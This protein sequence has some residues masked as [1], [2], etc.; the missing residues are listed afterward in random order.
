MDS[1]DRESR[2]IR[3]SAIGIVTNISLVAVK[4][5]I[6]V[7][8]NSIA[9]MMDAVNNLSD[10]L[11][12]VVT[13]IGTKL[14]MRTPDKKHPFGYGR[15][16]YMTALIVAVIV[17]YAGMTALIESAEHILEPAET[18]YTTISLV[19]IAIAV[20]VKVILGRY[21]MSVGKATDSG[22][23]TASGA[24]ALFDAVLSTSVLASALILVTTGIS[25]EAYVGVLIS[26]FIIKSGL[27]M[28]KETLD[29]VLGQRSDPDVARRIKEIVRSEPGVIGAYD[30]VINNYGPGRD[31]AS[32]HAE[33]ESSMRAEDIDV[34]SRKLQVK[35]LE[36]TGITLTA[37]GIYSVDV[38]DP[39]VLAIRDRILEITSSHDWILEMHGFHVDTVEKTIRFD[40]VLSFDIDRKDALRT[41]CSEIGEAYP[42][43]RLS[44]VP[45]VDVSD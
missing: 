26:L 34:L 43:Y 2:I 10:A 41:I 17:L 21:T 40:I 44:V 7:L 12:S 8:S 27:E 35:V 23:L 5:F 39:E 4:M 28:I 11:S 9:V 16:E 15:I 30:L 25:L 32:I 29:D 3:T 33:V 19:I 37:I 1:S 45:D 18:D 6:G 13:I 20:L 22:A 38:S 14:S 36:E 42:E 31:Y 24:D